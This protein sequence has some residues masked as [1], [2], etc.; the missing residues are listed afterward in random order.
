[1][2]PFG[3][4]LHQDEDHFA[5]T[6]IL[7]SMSTTAP[8]AS[9]PLPRTS[10]EL[11]CSRRRLEPDSSGSIGRCR[12]RRPRSGLLGLHPS[13][14]RRVAR[15]H[16]ALGDRDDGRRGQLEDLVALRAGAACGDG[17]A[18][19]RD[20]RDAGED[21]PLERVREP[22]TD[23]EVAGVGGVGA[24]Q[25]QV[26]AGR[27]RART[28]CA[29]AAATSAGPN[30]SESAS[31]CTARVQPTAMAS[32]S[33]STASPGPR[34]APSRVPPVASAVWIAISTAPPRGG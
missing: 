2:T 5:T 6:P 14:D 19:D 1:M 28:N 33:C 4:G 15:R 29:I 17:V 9:G 10:T 16:A 7:T 3:V 34:S 25:H 8:A 22:D 11:G 26:D 27:P 21:R 24:H 30:C 31:M 32:R 18:V 12:S 13:D 23:L 20:I